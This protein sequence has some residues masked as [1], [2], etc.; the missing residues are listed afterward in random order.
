MTVC[1]QGLCNLFLD[2]L[3]L[4]NFSVTASPPAK[5]DLEGEASAEPLGLDKADRG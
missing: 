2:L 5:V 1:T 4:I 3:P